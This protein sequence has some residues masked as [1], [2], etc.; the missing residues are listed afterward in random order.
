MKPPLLLH[1][2][3][4]ESNVKRERYIQNCLAISFLPVDTVQISDNNGT[5]NHPNSRRSV[6]LAAEQVQAAQVTI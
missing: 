2:S 3:T 1:T 6:I 4:F 5:E